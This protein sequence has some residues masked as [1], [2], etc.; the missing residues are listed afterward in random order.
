MPTIVQN[1]N[2]YISIITNGQYRSV[3]LDDKFN[4]RLAEKNSYRE[5]DYF[6]KGLTDL[7]MFCLRLS[8]IDTMY[9]ENLPF[10]ILDDPFVNYDN[11]KM[12]M[13]LQLLSERSKKCQIIYFTCHEA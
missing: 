13:A 8:L 10:L 12:Q 3:S 11:Q 1:F 2:K 6:S 4:L 5:F 9:G 7:G